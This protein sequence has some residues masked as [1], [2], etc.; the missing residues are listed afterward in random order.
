MVGWVVWMWGVWR[1][2]AGVEYL[3][4][5]M[6]LTW[7][8]NAEEVYFNLS[9]PVIRTTYMDWWGVGFKPSSESLDKSNADITIVTK[10]GLSDRW[11]PYNACPS[12]DE[13]H[14][15]NNSLTPLFSYPIGSE[16]VTGW[17]RP[18]HTGDVY[19]IGLREGE[20]YWLLWAIGKEKEGGGVAMHAENNKGIRKVRMT[21]EYVS[22]E[23]VSL[24]AVG[25]LLR[26]M[27]IIYA[28]I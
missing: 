16:H 19:D 7:R 28:F 24:L 5:E 3:P 20:E 9:I 4:Y 26:A 8:I 21:N 2:W 23:T 14:G 27:G 12:P 18:L 17:S 15:G 6:K 11:A 25:D 1:V 22:E 10:S 13:L